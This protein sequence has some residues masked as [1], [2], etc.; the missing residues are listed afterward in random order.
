VVR[1]FEHELF[2]NFSLHIGDQSINLASKN[3]AQ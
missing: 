1:G 3:E 2:V